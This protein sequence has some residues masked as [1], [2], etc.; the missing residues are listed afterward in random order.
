MI[1]KHFAQDVLPLA[2][3][4]QD[5]A[6]G[7]HRKWQDALLVRVPATAWV[8]N[9]LGIVRVDP[10][11][12]A[13]LSNYAAADVDPLAELASDGRKGLHRLL[14]DSLPATLKSTYG[15]MLAWHD[16]ASGPAQYSASS[17]ASDTNFADALLHLEMLQASLVEDYEQ[18][19]RT[20]TNA[21]PGDT[22]PLEITEEGGRRGLFA[23][24]DLIGQWITDPRYKESVADSLL[25]RISANASVN[26]A[27]LEYASMEANE[28]KATEMSVAL[29]GA[30][31]ASGIT[32]VPDGLLYGA[33]QSEFDEMIRQLLMDWFAH[34]GSFVRPDSYF[35]RPMVASD[36]DMVIRGSL[37]LQERY[38]S[39]QGSAGGPEA[40][41]VAHGAAGNRYI[42]ALAMVAAFY[43]HTRIANEVA[44]RSNPAYAVF[45]PRGAQNTDAFALRPHAAEVLMQSYSQIFF[46]NTDWHIL[47]TAVSA[48][49][50]R[51][52]AVSVKRAYQQ[53]L[54]NFV[55]KDRPA[56]ELLSIY[57]CIQDC[58][59]PAFQG[60]A[61]VAAAIARVQAR[62][63]QAAV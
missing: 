22:T 39:R 62:S 13:S 24:K 5:T 35:A 15:P 6:D 46:S 27:I 14:H 9:A 1:Q 26:R 19:W 60:E 31:N 2:A 32:E 10:S 53:Q 52:S 20:S 21:S 30:L 33:S 50:S 51:P 47:A 16:T 40:A 7:Y 56:T 25:V 59:V 18:S 17:L 61:A 42:F 38:L 36:I 45:P 3:V 23:L 28:Q 58:V 49:M 8:P 55:V 44:G 63:P 29:L 57:H 4:F 54:L 48:R 37:W 34:G 11:T 41:R 12:P 43:A